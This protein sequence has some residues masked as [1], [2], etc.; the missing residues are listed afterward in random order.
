MDEKSEDES[1][2]INRR[3]VLQISGAA[4]SLSILGADETQAQESGPTEIEDW[5]DLNDIRNSS[6]EDYI[7]TTD[8]NSE[9]TGYAEHVRDQNKGWK[10]IDFFTGTLNGDGYQISDLIIDRPS[11]DAI[12]LFD[13]VTG[14]IINLSLVD[15]NITGNSFI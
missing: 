8:L 2:R 9:T 11:E 14:K 6:S 10:P 3:H 15:V 7:L 4:G 5:Y 1:L 13:T 12:G